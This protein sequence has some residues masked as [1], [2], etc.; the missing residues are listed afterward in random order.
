MGDSES[1]LSHQILSLTGRRSYLVDEEKLCHDLAS[2][3]R[4]E[5]GAEVPTCI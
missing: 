2:V 3:R 1:I 4:S 5:E